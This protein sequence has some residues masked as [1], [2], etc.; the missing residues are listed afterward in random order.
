MNMRIKMMIEREKTSS[1]FG[2]VVFLFD[3]RLVVTM[4]TMMLLKL[5]K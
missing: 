5:D 2:D 4:M 1:S 3:Q